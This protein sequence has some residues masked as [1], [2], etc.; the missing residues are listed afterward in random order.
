M[1]CSIEPHVKENRLLREL[2]KG[3]IRKQTDSLITISGNGNDELARAI[4]VL[5]LYA[6]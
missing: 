6:N 1:T 4:A 3:H 2:R 5:K